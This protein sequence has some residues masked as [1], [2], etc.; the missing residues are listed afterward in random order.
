MITL[1]P[2]LQELQEPFLLKDL[3]TRVAKF[4]EEAEKYYVL[5]I[6][7]TLNIKKV[8]TFL[9]I[10]GKEKYDLSYRTLKDVYEYLTTCGAI[11]NCINTDLV[12]A[13]P[14]GLLC[15]FNNDFAKIIKLEDSP[16]TITEQ[17]IN[18]S[19][20]SYDDTVE[21][22]GIDKEGYDVGLSEE[23]GTYFADLNKVAAIV[24][25]SRSTLFDI[26]VTFDSLQTSDNFL[27]QAST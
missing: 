1:E 10:S 22:T 5:E 26:P 25:K 9:Y 7:S 3:V 13:L 2:T 17:Y 14:A 19:I 6:S 16:F 15:D 12:G 21:V 8:D 27:I 24:Y 11:V 18:T 4:S 23:A 20:N